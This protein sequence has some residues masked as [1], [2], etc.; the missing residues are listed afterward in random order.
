MREKDENRIL[1][2]NIRNDRIEMMEKEEWT[3]RG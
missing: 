1:S 3:D 2:T